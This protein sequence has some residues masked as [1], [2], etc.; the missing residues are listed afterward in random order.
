MTIVYYTLLSIINVHSGKNILDS[1]MKK[2]I[3]M[4]IFVAAHLSH[5]QSQ[6]RTQQNREMEQ[7]LRRRKELG[8]QQL[9]QKVCP[10]RRSFFY[11]MFMI[12]R[13]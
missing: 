6:E 13:N 7:S 12:D 1:N 10:L 3:I 8:E 5:I 11:A 2:Y 9:A 4:V